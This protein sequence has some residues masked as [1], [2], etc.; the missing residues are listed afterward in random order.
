MHDNLN[1]PSSQSGTDSIN[2]GEPS[3]NQQLND[4]QMLKSLMAQKKALL[5]MNKYSI[6]SNA[7][8]GL[9][10]AGDTDATSG[11]TTSVDCSETGSLMTNPVSEAKMYS[12]Q[13]Q[14]LL[15]LA[16]LA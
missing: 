11:D 8:T 15:E 9:E 3:L 2:E 12:V 4:Q 7:S 10:A 5:L 13:K 6:D 16:M 14:L 1:S